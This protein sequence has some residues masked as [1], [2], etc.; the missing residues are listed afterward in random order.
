MALTL[1]TALGT[2]S[3]AAAPAAAHGVRCTGYVGLTFD[4]GP[5]ADTTEALLRELRR[6]GVRATMFNIG[7]NAAANPALV[8]AQLRARMWV[9]NHSWTHPDLTAL[10]EQ[11]VAVEIGRTQWTL[12]RL[13]GRWPTLFRP[14]FGAT[15][16]SVR[17]IASRFGLTE[18]LWTVDSQDWNGASTAE[19]VRRAS[20]AVDGDVILMHDGL[21]TT[22]EAVGQIA[23]DLR[24]RGLCAGAISPRTGRAVAPGS[25]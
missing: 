5:Y 7:Q 21:A 14:P 12:L 20:A 15:N 2:V 17:G 23:A 25:V 13:T 11:E 6:A 8:R 24:A 22:I 1:A 18:V 4:D 9:A 19:I 16:D 3:A 10:T